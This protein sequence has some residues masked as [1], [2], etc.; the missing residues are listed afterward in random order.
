M[1]LLRAF[2]ARHQAIAALLIA[3][4]LCMKVLVPAGYMIGMGDRILTVEICADSQGGRVTTQIV[5]PGNG[6]SHEGQGEHSKSDG[7]CAFSSLS[8]ASLSAADPTLLAIALI[9]I[10]ALGFVPINAPRP[11]QQ[12]HLRPPLRGPPALV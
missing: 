7:T 3:A 9:F 4:A 6:Q 11:V 8:F 12:S 5:I 10:M 1:H 2:P